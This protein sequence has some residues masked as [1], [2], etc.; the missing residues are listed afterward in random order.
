[1]LS[2]L[3][4]RSTFSALVIVFS[5]FCVQVRAEKI[6]SHICGSEVVNRRGID[7]TPALKACIERAAGQRIELLPGRYEIETT[8][9]LGARS[10]LTLQTWGRSSAAACLSEGAPECAVLVGSVRNRGDVLFN[11]LGAKN[12][13]LNYIAIDGN[14]GQRRAAF[15]DVNLPDGKGYNATIHD[16]QNCRFIGFASVRALRGT[17]LEFDG[18]HAV[19]ERVLFR[20]NGWDIQSAPDS[21]VWRYADG[22]TVWSSKNIR[23]TDSVFADN[24]DIDLILGNAPGAVIE[25][26]LFSNTHSYAFAALMLDNFTRMPGDFSGAVIRKN[27]IECGEGMCGI[28]INIGPHM[29]YA[30]SPVTG[31]DIFEN[32]VSGARQGIL[33]NGAR[34]TRLRKNELIGVK[35]Y[36]GHNCV[37]AGVS[38]SHADEVTFESNSVEAQA[39]GLEK[40]TPQGLAFAY[41]SPEGTDPRI[42]QI[43]RETLGRNPD[44]EGG[45]SLTQALAQGQTLSSIRAGAV[46][47]AEAQLLL[48]R[49]SRQWL[50]RELD[51]K[52]RELWTDYM[53]QGGTVAKLQTALQ[54][55]PELDDGY[56]IIVI[57]GQS[58][59]VGAG[60]GSYRDSMK[61]PTL[62]LR[63]F[64]LGRNIENCVAHEGQVI[65][66]T[67]TLEHWFNCPS[68]KAVG[69]GLPF[70]RR[71][72]AHRLKGSRK[73]LILPGA[74]GG[75]TVRQWQET[76]W[77][78]L[79][80]Q[81]RQALN[82]GSG[83]NRIVAFLWSQGESDFV[84]CILSPMDKNCQYSA[85]APVREQ[86]RERTLQI[87][88]EFRREFDPQAQVPI[89]AT[90][91]V[92]ALQDLR[93]DRRPQAPCSQPECYTTLRVKENKMEFEEELLRVQK[94][95]RLANFF[96]I[97]TSGLTS[98]GEV[99]AAIPPK[100]I[101]LWYNEARLHFSAEAF[102]GMAE[103]MWR[104]FLSQR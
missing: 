51:P 34:G 7:A 76:L 22:L 60:R 96:F 11:S 84:N 71:W 88:K 21:K 24:T 56:D 32:T 18:D 45:R 50:H 78:A 42:S 63:I 92:P 26:N 10:D 17:A 104:V 33:T 82:L 19:F 2:P 68:S 81:I 90:G 64:Q 40:C 83:Q 100:E 94:Q 67:E 57:G 91:F 47:S 15:G 93:L 28:G 38:W 53:L 14:I 12:L 99:G 52:S 59:A 36:L 49:L 77:P 35:N 98:N 87:F 72:A 27:R 31:G 85:A 5:F 101:P 79:R 103:R 65:P 69:F 37:T 48:E 44:A 39:S 25:N 20:D 1:M 73:V 75:S 41:Y 30:A 61:S 55:S 6:Q 4:V 43:Y 97:P 9:D 62:D 70:A 58:N 3:W 13:S 66:A 95:S 29:W 8:L 89:L 54:M 80:A 46:T 102:I 16:C 23:I 74:Y 86:W